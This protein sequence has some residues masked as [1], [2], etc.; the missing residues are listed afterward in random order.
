MAACYVL[1][2]FAV[3][4]AE[5]GEGAGAGA[6]PGEVAAGGGVVAVACAVEDADD[7]VADGGEQGA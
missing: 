6:V 4:E 7:S 3:S 1:V 2:S 5:E